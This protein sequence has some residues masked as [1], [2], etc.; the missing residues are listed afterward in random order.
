[1]TGSHSNCTRTNYAQ[2]VVFGKQFAMVPST[3][4]PDG[5]Q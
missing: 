2:R 1:L 4:G 3:A 5:P